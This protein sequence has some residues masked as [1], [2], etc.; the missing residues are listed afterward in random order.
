[1]V[2]LVLLVTV[3]FFVSRTRE[4]VRDRV[5]SISETSLKPRIGV[6]KDIR[7]RFVSPATTAFAAFMAAP[8]TDK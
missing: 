1:M 5:D 7:G 2:Y 4:T 8:F 3:A 6:P